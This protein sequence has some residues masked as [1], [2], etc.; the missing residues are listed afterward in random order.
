VRISEDQRKKIPNAKLQTPNKSQVQSSKP[1]PALRAWSL[2]LGFWCFDSGI[3]LEAGAWDSMLRIYAHDHLAVM[4]KLKEPLTLILSPLRAGRGKQAC[5]RFGSLVGD[6][7]TVP[8]KG[9][10]RLHG[11]G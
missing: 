3:S 4:M 5:T 1:R 7:D 10:F 2:E 9:S 11:I 6:P 8:P